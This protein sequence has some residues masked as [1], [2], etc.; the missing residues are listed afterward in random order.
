MKI[1]LDLEANALLIKFKDAKSAKTKEIDE[2]TILDV[3]E[4]GNPIAIEMLNVIPRI[5]IEQFSNVDVS[6]PVEV[7][8]I[9]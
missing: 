6:I 5:P 1:Q 9:K 2:D 8:G 4:N 3:D 7:H